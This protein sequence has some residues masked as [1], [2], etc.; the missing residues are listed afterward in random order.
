MAYRGREGGKAAI[1][2]ERLS[3][4]DLASARS[5]A[6]LA[7]S[8]WLRNIGIATAAKIANMVTTTNSSMRENPP[9]PRFLR[10][11]NVPFSLHEKFNAGLQNLETFKKGV[12]TGTASTFRSV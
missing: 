1:A 12:W 8:F 3:A 2:E 4:A 5:D 7:L 9:V 6:S 11:R 10:K